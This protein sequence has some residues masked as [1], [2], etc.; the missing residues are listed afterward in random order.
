MFV[1]DDSKFELRPDVKDDGAGLRLLQESYRELFGEEIKDFHQA[2]ADHEQ[3]SHG[4]WARGVDKIV[5]VWEDTAEKIAEGLSTVED[6]ARGPKPKIVG[7][8]EEA[9][10]VLDVLKKHHPDVLAHIEKITLADMKTFNDLIEEGANEFIFGFYDTD[11]KEITL[12]RDLIDESVA[13]ENYKDVL[14][15]DPINVTLA[16]VLDHE[17]GH[18]AYHHGARG[19]WIAARTK[20]PQLDR[21]TDYSAFDEDE[22]FAETYMLY[23]HS[24]GEAR[25]PAYVEAFDVMRRALR[26]VKP[27]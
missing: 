27:A 20:N 16:T 18:A 24:N 7:T 17:I 21:F 22:S 23:I 6:W 2:G 9:E 1:L 11:A 5:N 12:N 25:D 4:N 8:K 10:R 15:R 13:E 3:E 26:N 19:T 14:G